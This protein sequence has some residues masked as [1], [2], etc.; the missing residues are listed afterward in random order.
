[1]VVLDWSS[2]SGATFATSNVSKS[3]S[4]YSGTYQAKNAGGTVLSSVAFNSIEKLIV[5]GKQV[6]LNPPADPG[7][8]I[9]RSSTAT[10]TTSSA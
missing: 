10:A 1:M 2:L 4:S 8:K 9:S 6:D 3:G 7:V 5:S